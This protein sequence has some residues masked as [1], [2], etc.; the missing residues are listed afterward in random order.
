MTSLASENLNKKEVVIISRDK[1]PSID[2]VIVDGVREC[3]GEHRDFRRNAVLNS[4]LPQSGRTSISWTKLNPKESLAVHSHPA[5]SMIIVAEGSGQFQGGQAVELVAGDVVFVPAGALHG[6]IGGPDSMHCLSIQFE[7]VGL[8][9][10][11]ES[12]RVRFEK[13]GYEKLL[14]IN[15]AELEKLSR[16]SFFG[17]AK[18][19]HLEDKSMMEFF[20]ANLKLWSAKFQK[21]IYTRQAN[22]SAPEFRDIFMTHMMEE[23]DHDKL[24]ITGA[25]VEW[26]PVIDGC[27][28]W[29]VERMRVAD[30]YEKLVL[31]HLV[32][33][34]AGDEYHRLASES[35]P[36]TD[37]QEYFETHAELDDGHARLGNKLLTGLSQEK[38]EEL[39]AV[40]VKGWR[41]LEA[42]LERIAD[43]TIRQYGALAHE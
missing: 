32:L 41:M 28:E 35:L 33:E 5:D 17:L 12:P 40:S 25:P 27:G 42:V 4:L 22:V 24:I 9:E 30:D 2:S 26:D 11:T 16:G 3:L 36:A 23:L 37:S 34:S 39:I 14:E 13:S 1:I 20:L 19:S 6:F 8:Y 38:Y 31:V 43:N 7:G 29:F 21:I 18:N 10:L 15:E